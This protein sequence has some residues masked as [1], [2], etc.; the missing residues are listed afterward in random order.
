MYKEI[1]YIHNIKK[2][3]DTKYKLN[4]YFVSTLCSSLLIKLLF[5]NTFSINVL[6]L[7]IILE[8]GKINLFIILI[9]LD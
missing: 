8:D 5:F 4:F 3:V 1:I 2:G 9:N 7:N 6:H